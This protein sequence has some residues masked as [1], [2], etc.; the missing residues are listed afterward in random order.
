MSMF[1]GLFMYSFFSQQRKLGS[2]TG[3]FFV[4]LFFS[5]LNDQL[6]WT[7]G[8]GN[9]LGAHGLD[10]Q[11][12]S[13][14]PLVQPSHNFGCSLHCSLQSDVY[15]RTPN[16]DRFRNL[17]TCLTVLTLELDKLHCF[18]H[19][20]EKA[21]FGPSTAVRY[22]LLY[23]LISHIYVILV[24]RGLAHLTGWHFYSNHTFFDDHSTSNNCKLAVHNRIGDLIAGIHFSSQNTVTLKEHL[25]LLLV[26]LQS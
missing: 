25:T 17:L 22:R 26:L 12:W 23:S 11:V 6:R 9:A 13:N 3:C 14:L 2:F 5:I 24:L 1:D 18:W 8:K 10:S 20:P 4:C 21:L 19:V 16:Q 7:V 15:M